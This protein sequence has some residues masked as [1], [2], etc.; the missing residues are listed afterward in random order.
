MRASETDRGPWDMHKGSFR[1]A[2]AAEQFGTCHVRELRP[3]FG[4]KVIFLLF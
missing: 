1:E 4:A 3:E 2:R